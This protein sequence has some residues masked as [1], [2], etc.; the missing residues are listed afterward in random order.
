M[1]TIEIESVTKMLF[2]DLRLDHCLSLLTSHC[3]GVQYYRIRLVRYCNIT[4][5]KRNGWLIDSWHP[6]SWPPL[7]RSAGGGGGWGGQP[8]SQ[9]PEP[10]RKEPHGSN[11]FGLVLMLYLDNTGVL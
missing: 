6:Y 11:G 2:E 10:Y 3:L 7:L 8:S 9:E 1:L 5:P 4:K